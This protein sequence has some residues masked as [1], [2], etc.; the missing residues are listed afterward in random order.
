MRGTRSVK[1]FRYLEA[2]C[3]Q[4]SEPQDK[5]INDIIGSNKFEFDVLLP[6]KID[7][8]LIDHILN[9]ESE[10]KEQNELEDENQIEID[11][12]LKQDEEEE[13]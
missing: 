12:I 5:E 13:K 1:T 7:H 10:N 6:S 2:K 9:E 3:R 8:I 4:E 11:R